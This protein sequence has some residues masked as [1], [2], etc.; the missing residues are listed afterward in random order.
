MKQ[1]TISDTTLRPPGA[2]SP[3]SDSIDTVTLELLETWRLQD[4]TDDPEE[5]RAAEQ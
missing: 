3:S 2:H 4:A 5:L 1:H